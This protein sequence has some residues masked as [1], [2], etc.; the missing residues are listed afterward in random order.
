MS[1]A[2]LVGVQQQQLVYSE[3]GVTMILLGRGGTAVAL[4][5]TLPRLRCL[6]RNLHTFSTTLI[7]ASYPPLAAT[8]TDALDIGPNLS[9]REY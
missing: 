7:R 3:I 8:S 4:V 6:V 5:T 1:A 2:V 9:V